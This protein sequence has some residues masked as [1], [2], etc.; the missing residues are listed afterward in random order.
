MTLLNQVGDDKFMLQAE[1]YMQ[2]RLGFL[3]QLKKK[4]PMEGISY[5]VDK[6]LDFMLVFA[7]DQYKVFEETT[8][9]HRILRVP[10]KFPLFATFLFTKMDLKLIKSIPQKMHQ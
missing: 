1:H 8:P 10:N 3:T 5:E 4:N 6:D 2:G 7:I 9:H